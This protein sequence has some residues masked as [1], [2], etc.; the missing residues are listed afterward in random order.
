MYCIYKGYMHAQPRM[1]STPRVLFK[2]Q[3]GMGH[4][5]RFSMTYG[6]IYVFL[7]KHSIT[8]DFN[9]K[10]VNFPMDKG[11][12]L[13]GSSKETKF[14]FLQIHYEN[15]AKVQDLDVKNGIRLYLTKKYR[16]IEFGILTV[17]TDLLSISLPPKMKALSI[18]TMCPKE[19][20]NV[21]KF[22]EFFIK[23]TK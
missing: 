1:D 12:P 10:T 11:Y 14:F 20:M 19:Y 18:E 15:S 4:R 7:N 8:Y 17:A 22:K 2:N 23:I 5:W 9:L 13:G 21:N 3:L 16:P 6:L